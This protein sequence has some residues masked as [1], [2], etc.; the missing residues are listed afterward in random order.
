MGAGYQPF[1]TEELSSGQFKPGEGFV[2][3]FRFRHGF[4]AAISEDQYER[5]ERATW[6]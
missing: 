1:V 4:V 3:P 5:L 2:F 6:R